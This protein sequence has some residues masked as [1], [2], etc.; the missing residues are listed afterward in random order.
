M[1]AKFKLSDKDAGLLNCLASG[2]IDFD[3]LGDDDL[4]RAINI[5]GQLVRGLSVELERRGVPDLA[6]GLALLQATPEGR[7]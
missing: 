2:L 4:V 1:H 3:V 6:Q 7:G 5:V